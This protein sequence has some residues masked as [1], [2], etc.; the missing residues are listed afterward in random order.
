MSIKLE[1]ITKVF[2]AQRVLDDV[3]LTIAEGEFF[4]VLGPSGCGKSTLL[5]LISG[6]EPLDGGRIEINGREVASGTQHLPPEARGV[7]V[8]FQSY[9]LWPHMSVA[10]NVAF[11]LETAGKTKSEITRRTDECLSTVE[12]TRFADR[13]PA[14]LSGGQR[15]RVALARC[16]AQGASTILMDEP[17]ANLDPHLRGA[18]EEELSAFHKA[19]GA[20]TLFI[21]HDQREAM[22]LADRIAI[23]WEGRLL[24]A[25]APE[26]IYRRPKNRQV[27]GFIGQGA[28]T[29]VAVLGSQGSNANVRLAGCEFTVSATPGTPTGTAALLLRPEDLDVGAADARLTGRIGRTVYRGGFHE[30]EISL[31]GCD[32]PLLARLPLKPQAGAD[33]GISIRSGWLL[34]A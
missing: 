13:K 26:V 12:L 2:G 21:T 4:V 17:L 28:I 30:A 22:A 9:A 23:L 6:L 33:V 27:A 19:S 31:P 18:M 5:R 24:Q 7:G 8:V 20:T 14:D 16:L 10:A 25:D 15:Q 32:T 1:Q 3:S 34:P 29:T 11:P